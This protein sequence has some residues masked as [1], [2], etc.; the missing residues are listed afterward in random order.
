MY[1]FKRPGNWGSEC[2]SIPQKAEELAV[3]MLAFVH[4]KYYV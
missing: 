2:W 1:S 4:A 3:V